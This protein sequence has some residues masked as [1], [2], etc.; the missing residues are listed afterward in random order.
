MSEAEGLEGLEGLRDATEWEVGYIDATHDI[1]ASMIAAAIHK[2]GEWTVSMLLGF[3]GQVCDMERLNDMID[4][5]LEE[6]P[7]L[8][9]GDDED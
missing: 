4:D 5:L 6:A 2:H 8:E 3:A 9:A 7:S 1:L